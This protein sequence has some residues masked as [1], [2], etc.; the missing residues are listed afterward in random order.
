MRKLGVIFIAVV[1]LFGLAAFGLWSSV[2]AQVTPQNDAKMVEL[3]RLLFFDPDLSVNGKQSCASCHA[4]EAG[5]S[6]PDSED[7]LLTAVYEGTLD[8]RFGNRKPPSSSY[9]GDSPTLHFDKA[10]GLWIGGMFWDGR[11]TG[12]VLGD[13]VAEQAQGPFLNPLEMA[14]PHSR[15][16]V[17]KVAHS[18]Y[19]WLFKEVWGP[20]SLKYNKQEE[21]DLAYERI[22][23][24]I[25]AYE[26]S[27]EVDPYDSRFDLFYDKAKAKGLDVSKIRCGTMSGGMDGGMMGGMC[28]PKDANGTMS[29]YS[30]QKYMGLGLNGMELQGLAIFNDPTRANCA[31]CHSLAEGS[32][33]YP[34]FTDFS[35]HNL[36]VPKNPDNPFYGMDLEWNPDGAGW[37]DYGLG[38]F[39]KN[40]GYPA[41]VYTIENGKFKVPS[42]RNVDKR[43]TPEFVKAYTHNGYFK[44]LT[45]II[46]FYSWRGLVM[47]GGLGMGGSGMD[48][49]SGGM[50]GGGMGGGGMGGGGMGGGI[51]PEMMCSPDLFPAPEM[52]ENMTP[53]NHFNFMSDTMKIEAFL[54]TLSDQ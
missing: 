19:A 6:G 10:L 7:N 40:S 30:W 41:E 21:V 22:A 1:L 52:A 50:G 49:C 3:G 47:N 39:L 36:G 28:A 11:A 33:G 32:A 43:P 42:L 23:R 46:I 45:D 29:P 48:G 37:V 34:L 17:I 15:Q 25:A 27:A 44:S 9:V 13:P 51:T 31:F 18:E 5:F 14:M 20:Q 8:G 53:M 26:R 12:A 4:P 35:Y 38:A 54:K 16:V 2:S 24:S